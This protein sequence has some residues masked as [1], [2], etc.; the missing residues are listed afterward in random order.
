M[1]TLKSQPQKKGDNS[2][3][4]LKNGFGTKDASIPSAMSLK[5]L[6]GFVE[7]VPLESTS[8]L[9]CVGILLFILIE[10]DN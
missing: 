3:S 7:H 2:W 5:I 1:D 10:Y 9:C 4:S 6:L 8:H